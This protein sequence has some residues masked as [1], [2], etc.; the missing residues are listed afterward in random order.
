THDDSSDYSVDHSNDCTNAPLFKQNETKQKENNTTAADAIEFYRE[1]F[2]D[3]DSKEK[4]KPYIA[5]SLLHWASE[6]GEPL[7]RV[8]LERTLDQGQ[9]KWVYVKRILQDWK[10]K[11]VQTV[12]DVQAEDATFKQKREKRSKQPGRSYGRRSDEVVPD[13][14]KERN[15]KQ[16][17]KV[18]PELSAAEEAEEMAELEE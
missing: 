9:T 1:N 11:G 13:W 6:I 3:P 5:K 7:V 10:D 8:A 12:D 18:T 14:F 2:M 17:V 4:I 16:D 15:K